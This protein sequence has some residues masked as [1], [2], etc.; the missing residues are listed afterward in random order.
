MKKPIERMDCNQLRANEIANKLEANGFIYRGGYGKL[1][2][3]WG[4]IWGCSYEGP[5]GEY[6]SIDF[7]D[8]SA[9]KII[10]ATVFGVPSIPDCVK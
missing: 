9:T 4:D 2:T 3:H 7:T 10:S 6:V 5:D 1:C 8:A